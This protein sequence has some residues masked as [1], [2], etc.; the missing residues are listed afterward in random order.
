MKNAN[1]TSGVGTPYRGTRPSA[2]IFPSSSLAPQA[3]SP[4]M[5]IQFHSLSG[6]ARGCKALYGLKIKNMNQTLQPPPRHPRPAAVRKY[7]ALVARIFTMEMN[8][9]S[10]ENSSSPRGPSRDAADRTKNVAPDRSQTQPVLHSFSDG[11]SNPSQ[12]T[13][14]TPTP[15]I[16]PVAASRQ[17]TPAAEMP[18]RIKEAATKSQSPSQ[19]MA[20]DSNIFPLL[21]AHRQ[22]CHSFTK[23]REFSRP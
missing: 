3:S 2:F 4:V 13:L 19:T 12:T 11:G 16:S 17:R 18:L 10:A 23:Q 6:L 1:T 7:V 20:R 8:R 14:T 22:S 21:P 5:V 9:E 15:P